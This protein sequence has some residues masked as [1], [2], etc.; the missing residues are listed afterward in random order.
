LIKASPVPY[1]IVRATQFFEFVGGIAQSASD[2]QVVRL[3]TAQMQPIA[4]A[5]VAAALAEVALAEPAGGTIELAGPERIA[6]NQLVEQFLNAQGDPRQVT[7]AGHAGYFG[8]AVDDSSLTPGE[9]PRVGPTRFAQ[10]LERAVAA[11]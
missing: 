10:W 5:D 9:H 8:A 1:T 6:M 11:R 7:T 4:A 3:P 2:G